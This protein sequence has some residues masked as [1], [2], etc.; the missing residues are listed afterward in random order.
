V[1]S[2]LASQRPAV[3]EGALMTSAALP[4]FG[5]AGAL[6]PHPTSVLVRLD[7]TLSF[8]YKTVTFLLCSII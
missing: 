5:L 8:Y 3:R 4:G 1:S 6:P 7:T 2:S